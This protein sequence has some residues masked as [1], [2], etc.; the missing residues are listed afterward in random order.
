MAKKQFGPQT[1]LYPEPAVLVGANVDGKPNFMAVAWTGIAGGT[2][3]M[4]TV[5][6]RHARYTLKGVRRNMTFSV[7]IPSTDLV[8]ETDYCGLVSGAK[9]DKVKDC[10]FK[11]FYGRLGTAPLIEQCPVNMECEVQQIINLGSHSLVIGKIAETHVSEDCLTDGQPDVNK[12]KPLIYNPRPATG[13]Y[14]VGKSVA[15][16]FSVGK[17]IKGRG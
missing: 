7:N 8:K 3:P 6:L 15:A 2:P 17:Q 16:S 13:Y 14:A 9:T 5:A 12:I 11:V 4:I 1:W 10:K